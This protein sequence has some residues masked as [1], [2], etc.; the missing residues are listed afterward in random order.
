MARQDKYLWLAD[1]GRNFLWVVD[2]R[3]D[4]VVNRIELI[5]ELSLDPTPDLMHLSP[6]GSHA[7]VALRGPTPLSGDPHVSTGSTPGVGVLKVTQAG[8]N[9][10]F[11]SIARIT[12]LDTSVNPSVERADVHGIAVRLKVH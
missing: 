3:T 2:T 8:R 7:V 11:E 10:R 1:R 4:Q 12:N 9:A 6:N 5:N